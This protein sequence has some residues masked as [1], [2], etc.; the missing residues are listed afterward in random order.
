MSAACIGEIPGDSGPAG[1]ADAPAG[2]PSS[3]PG[4]RSKPAPPPTGGAAAVGG[5][6]SLRLL[7]RTELRNTL[8]DTLGV[9]ITGNV[10]L[11]LGDSAATGF[12][13]PATDYI[14]GND[15]QALD[16][17]L[18]A[19]ADQ[20]VTRL[21]GSAGACRD[22]AGVPACVDTFVSGLGRKL[23]R[24]P[25]TPAELGRYR[26]L[27]ASEKT[28][29]DHASGLTLAVRGL[30][31]SP[32]FLYRS[33]IGEAVAPGSKIARLDDWEYASALAFTFARTA[34]DDALLNA[35]ESGALRSPDRVRA[36][37]RR[38]LLGP[39]GA[40]AVLDFYTRWMRL[41]DLP[42]VEKSG[43][44]KPL[45]TEAVRAAASRELAEAVKREVLSG[46]GNF[47]NLL[48]TTKGFGADKAA[49]Q[50]LASLYGAAAPAAGGAFEL[51]AKTRA[52]VFTQLAFLI[53]VSKEA[54]S[55]AMHTGALVFDKLLCQALPSP[56]DNVAAM[57]FDPDPALS[58]RQNMT[59]RTSPDACRPCHGVLN[60]VA[61]PFEGYDAV[62][63]VRTQIDG[64]PVD[65]SGQLR[66]TR[67]ADGA[68]Q[69]V[70]G[71]MQ[72]LARSTQVTEC[73]AA[74]WLEYMLG[75]P[76]RSEDEPSLRRA[77]DGFA[78]RGFDVPSLLAELATSDA[79]VYRRL[80]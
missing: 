73:H 1:V 30:L 22:G 36:E 37:A 2:P 53:G 16:D 33:E 35:A 46:Q 65:V 5:P 40:D 62:G 68:F 42:R 28:R 10:D 32:N 79:F 80:P 57:T 41:Q 19:V 7:S 63:R 76:R 25:M 77:H 49:A 50:T 48:T 67:D 56:P 43:A 23:F 20:V 51:D 18:A 74:H 15:F 26:N 69:G 38:L 66:N 21:Q 9:P 71:M 45:F 39:R 14:G 34:P 58:R 75:R 72:L 70:V 64:F 29:K 11:V 6:A 78:A 44:F 4:E 12:A 47:R 52:G 60:D 55:S 17:L 13:D 61:M 24:R 59:L 27:Y 3:T 54:D 8:Q 31:L